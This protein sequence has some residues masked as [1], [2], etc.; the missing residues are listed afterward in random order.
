M[1]KT[2]K[3]QTLV[4]VG[5]QWG[6]EGK[7]KITDYFADQVDYVVRFQ[8]GNN[9]GHTVVVG[10]KTYKLHL[11]PSGV[12]Y[13]GKRV[14][15]GN[16][17]VVDPK[18]LLE[19]IANLKKQ[20]KEVNLLLSERAHL[21][22][23]YHILM[24]GVLENFKGKLAA[25]TTKRGI[26]LAYADK[27]NRLGIR[28]IDLIEKD[29]FK[30]KFKN[31][32]DFN[33]KVLTKVFNVPSEKLNGQQIFNQYLKYGRQLKKY[34]GD[35]SLEI[36]HAIDQGK[37][38][39]F[40]GAQGTLLDIDH[41]LYPHGTSSNTIAGGAIT[42]A[43]VSPRKID[44]ILGV[45]KAYLTRVGDG[46]VATEELGE[47]GKFLREKGQEYGAT[48]GRPRRC[49]WVDLVQLRYSHRLNGL[50]SLAITKIDVLG[51]LK[52]IPIC[53]KYKYKNSY[54]KEFPASL[55]IL[56]ECKPVYEIMDG[57]QDLSFEETEKIINH[58]YK[59]L[60]LNMK[61]YLNKISQDINVPIELISF[62][63]QRK[64]TLDLWK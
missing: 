45:V 32:F 48:T 13:K 58:G 14:V 19:E 30:E 35:A 55:K 42:G 21:I 34:I 41:G 62:G 27:A 44:K 60:P 23:P 7:G 16:G 22:F 52:K 64:M 20:G 11:I 49:G 51:G 26:G 4:I 40:E 36:N 53:T 2:N 24:D 6:D 46:P 33:K 5:C 47:M 61:K 1:E 56:R 63:P 59:Y 54:L 12:L 17:V 3:W 29:I 50:D 37:R 43:G 10:D 28:V 25:A 31:V 57:W 39:L 9:A 18:V 15:I 38:I 8:G